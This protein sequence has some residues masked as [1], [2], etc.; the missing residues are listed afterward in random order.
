MGTLVARLTIVGLLVFAGTTGSHAAAPCLEGLGPA[1]LV[2]GFT[3]SV[4]C[5]KDRLAVHHVGRVEHSGR[6]FEIYAYRYRLAPVCEDCAVHGGQRIIFMERGRY[7]GQYKSNFVQVSLRAG[8]LVLVPTQSVSSGPVTVK[9]TRD[10]PAKRLLV[11]GE[12]ISFF[13]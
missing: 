5:G 1:L 12:V 13:R 11:D 3:G 7:V 10:G 8:D 4:D 2:G 9:F 6:T